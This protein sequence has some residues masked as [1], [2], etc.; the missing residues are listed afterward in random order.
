M[1][2]VLLS[3][4]ARQAERVQLALEAG[5]PQPEAPREAQTLPPDAVR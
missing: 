3:P 1:I 2:A 4:N 5:P